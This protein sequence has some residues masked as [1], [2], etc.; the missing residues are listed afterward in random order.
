MI[1]NPQLLAQQL[2]N[3]VQLGVMLFLISAGLTLVLGILNLLNLTHGAFYMLAA[4]LAVEVYSKT[5]SFLLALVGAAA[6]SVLIAMVLNLLVMRYLYRRDHMTQ[7]LAT[8]GM[9]LFINEIVTVIWGQGALQMPKPD[10][11]QWTVPVFPGTVYPA[12]RLA[13]TIVGLIVA[14]GLYYGNHHTRLGSLI[15]AAAS[16]SDMLSALGI[17]VD[18]VFLSVFCLGVA[19]AA[20]AGVMVAP[21]VSVDNG[22]GDS[23]LILCFVVITIGGMGS[24]PGAFIAS[25]LVGLV[26][27]FGRTLLPQAFGFTLGPALSSMSVY[28]LM[29][30]VLVW[31]PRG[32]FAAHQ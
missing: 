21:L 8:F 30:M 27:T 6:A 28:L 11:L 16:N 19:L 2:L 23:V 5:G 29:A 24:V 12:Y 26:D 17:R 13:I 10:W 3:G 20:I 32:L 31:R 9:L 4:Y 15:R 22:M 14:V 7:L 18:R 1:L 25:L